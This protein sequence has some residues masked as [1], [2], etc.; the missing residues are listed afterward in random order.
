MKI[1]PLSFNIHQQN[2]YL[3]SIVSFQVWKPTVHIIKPPSLIRISPLLWL[4]EYF[5]SSFKDLCFQQ[6]FPTRY[7]KT[8][9]SSNSATIG[10][11]N[12][13]LYI[14]KT[15]SL[16]RYIDLFSHFRDT[17][18]NTFSARQQ[19]DSKF[20]TWNETKFWSI[21][22]F[23]VMQHSYV[24]DWVSPFTYS[25]VGAHSQTNLLMNPSPFLSDTCII[26]AVWH[27]R[28]QVFPG[29]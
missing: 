5:Q 27:W 10:T 4:T 23:A 7:M 6:H 19:N 17:S 28:Q 21:L 24:Q 11:N 14:Y 20:E 13:T 9:N 1:I 25:N 8:H 22:Q 12:E 2:Q 15:N 3:Y 18:S 29:Y 26:N 16:S